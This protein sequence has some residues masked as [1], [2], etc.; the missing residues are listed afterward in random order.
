MS[1]DV[2][3]LKPIDI[4]IEDL[5]EID[6]IEQLG[7]REIVE[8]IVNQSFPAAV[9]GVWLTDEF[10]VEALLSGEPVDSIHLTLRFGD[11]WSENSETQFLKRIES[12]CQKLQ[13][14]AFS[15]SDNTRLA[16]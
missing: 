1:F 15:V 6:N 10:S 5:S 16:P 8:H 14:V 2:I 13:S 3:I 9:D 11:S 7:K 12:I 4:S